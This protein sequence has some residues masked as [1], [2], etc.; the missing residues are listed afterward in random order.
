MK[1]I[2]ITI[3]NKPEL[4]DDMLQHEYKYIIAP[5]SRFNT[6]IAYENKIS[7]AV[8]NM[9]LDIDGCKIADNNLISK[10]THTPIELNKLSDGCKTAIYVYFRALVIPNNKEIINIAECGAN[11]IKYILEHFGNS[12]VVLYLNHWEIPGD[13]EMVF[14]L[15]EDTIINNTNELM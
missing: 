15:N 1:S 2:V 9:A 4:R 7:D 10:F 13:V 5:Y 14:R 8:R 3:I 6:V 11:A 12:D